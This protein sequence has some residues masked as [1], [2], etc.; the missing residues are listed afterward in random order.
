M[1][2]IKLLIL[3]L[4]GGLLTYEIYRLVKDIKSRKEKPPNKKVGD[5]NG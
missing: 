1:I 2:I 3:L 4:S 5:I